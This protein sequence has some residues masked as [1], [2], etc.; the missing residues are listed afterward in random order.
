M[1]TGNS[2]VRSSALSCSSTRWAFSAYL[3]SRKVCEL[4][5]RPLP[6]SPSSSISAVFFDRS[7]RVVASAF[8]SLCVSEMYSSASARFIGFPDT[9]SERSMIA[10]SSELGP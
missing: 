5:R 10:C 8:I 6:R 1:T 4:K 2:L 3:P 9:R 7:T